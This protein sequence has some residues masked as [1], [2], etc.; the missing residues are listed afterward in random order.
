MPGNY[1]WLGFLDAMVPGSH[2][3]HCRRHPIAT[4]LSAYK[5]YFG[6]EVPYSYHLTDLA[7]AYRQYDEYIEYWKGCFPLKKY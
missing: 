3:I 2:F 5:L 6:N 4:C 7:R 1:V